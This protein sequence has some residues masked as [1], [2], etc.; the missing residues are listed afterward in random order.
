MN[1]YIFS[2]TTDKEIDPVS[3]ILGLEQLKKMDNIQNNINVYYNTS[4]IKII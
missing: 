2:C 1:G 4:S 3:E